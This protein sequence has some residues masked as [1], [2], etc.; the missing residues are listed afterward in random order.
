LT[1][2]YDNRNRGIPNQDL[3]ISIPDYTNIESR[4]ERFCPYCNI[5]LS[6]L[7][8]SSGLNPSWYCGKCVIEYPEKSETKSTSRLST[9]QQ[10]SNNERPAVS[11]A[12]EPGL[13]RK[14]T[15]VKGGLAELAKRGSI[16]ITHYTES[17]TK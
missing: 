6:R 12:P 9:P 13:V 3:P 17:N 2:Y 16:K 15:Q 4:E 8:D 5:K 1:K 11:Y 14:K 10:K 7:I